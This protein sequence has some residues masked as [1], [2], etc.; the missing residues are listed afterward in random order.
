MNIRNIRVDKL[1]DSELLPA[2]PVLIDAWTERPDMNGIIN[3]L[4]V[5][6]FLLGLSFVTTVATSI[7]VTLFGEREIVLAI[8]VVGWCRFFISNV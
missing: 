3:D 7:L 6:G 5:Y 4:P 2:L 1:R 8:S